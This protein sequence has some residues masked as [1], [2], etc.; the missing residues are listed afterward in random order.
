[1]ASYGKV[2]GG[3][4]RIPGRTIIRRDRNREGGGGFDLGLMASRPCTLRGT[5]PC[6]AA[7]WVLV[8]MV[9][10]NPGKNSTAHEKTPPF[11][12]AKRRGRNREEAV[13]NRQKLM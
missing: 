11:A 3:S 9:K 6:W 12:G 1:M 8:E 7:A 2:K 10:E 4:A 13:K 5:N